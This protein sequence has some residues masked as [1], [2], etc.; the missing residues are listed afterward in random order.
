M[1]SG[2]ASRRAT[3]ILL[4][5]AVVLMAMVFWP[6]WQPLLVAAVLAGVL[7]PPYERLTIRLHGKRS[8]L[9][10]LFTVG[11]VLLILLPLAGIVLIAIREALG[12]A[13]VIKKTLASSGVEGL[14]ARA[15][16]PLEGWLRQ[17]LRHI[18]NQIDEIESQLASSGRWALSTLSWTLSAVGQFAFLLVMMLIAFFFL[19]RDGPQL[20]DWIARAT[21]LPPERMRELMREFRL[22]ARSILGANLITGAVQ[23][24]VATAG[25][26][27]GHAPSP[28]FFGL[29][30]LFASLIPSVGTALVTFPVAALVL[31]LGHRWSALFLGLW[32]LLMVGL[33]DNILRPM[34]IRGGARLH[35]ALVFFS[36][37]GGAAAFG[38]VGLFLGPLVLTFFLTA[39]RFSRRGRGELPW[40]HEP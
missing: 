16:N 27:I 10:A 32:A 6:L 13:A 24:A 25:Y 20:V 1:A 35:G 23:A 34:L 5:A 39:F 29:L 37:I 21:P 40:V 26:F 30:T 3:S 9:A 19:L 15:P 7:Y 28:I 12:A 36:L 8:L 11:T 38:A 17:I 33:I 2:T 31:L 22:V 4:G 14:I 18:P